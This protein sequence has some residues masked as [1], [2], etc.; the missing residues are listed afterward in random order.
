[1]NPRNIFNIEVIKIYKQLVTSWIEQIISDLGTM[2]STYILKPRDVSNEYNNY[3]IIYLNVLMEKPSP[4]DPESTTIKIIRIQLMDEYNVPIVVDR[5]DLETI[6]TVLKESGA[7]V[8]DE[9]A[10]NLLE[11]TEEYS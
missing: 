7:T 2:Y 1:M 10:V 4:Y 3:Y 11:K 9:E 6:L 5:E 8:N